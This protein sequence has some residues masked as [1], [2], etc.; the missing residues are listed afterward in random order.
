M[1]RSPYIGLHVAATGRRATAADIVESVVREIGTGALPAGSRLPPVRALEKQLGLSKNT[2]QAAYDE[3]VA[4]GV[5]EAREREGVFVLAASRQAAPEPVI[6]APPAVVVPPPLSRPD[7]APRGSIALSTVFIDPELLPTERIA[8]CARSVLRERM[9]THYDPQGYAPL[10]E[11]IAKRLQ[12]RGLDVEADD[13]VV[14]TGSQQSL[15]IVA[16][17]L[18]VRRI[19]V[20]SPV[21]AYAKILFETLG[22]EL[23]GLTLDPFGGIDLDTWDRALARKP[24]LAYLIP[25]FHNPTGYSYTSAELRGVLELCSKHG[26]AILEDDWGSDMLSDGEYRPMLRM[27]GGRD[28]LYVNSFTKKLLPSLRV[29]FVA[30]S[31]A[32][33]PTLVAMKRL[34]TLGNAWLTEAI[35]AEFLARGY[36]DTHLATLQT[37]LDARYAAC[38]TALDE[39]MPDG[40]KWT[41]PGGGPTLWLEIPRS[42]DLPALEAHL[43]RR[44]VHIASSSA[45]FVG[46]P[47]LHGFR[48]AYAYLHEDDMR[49]ALTIVADALRSLR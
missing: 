31:P 46:A 7:V 41:H 35:V 5:V 26:V 45:A 48:I 43:A 6:V 16:R 49:R 12:A 21:Y 15:D 27:L 32:L 28:V 36:Y 23:V 8:E 37:A 42:I 29:G 30:A 38:L 22:H 4:R 24:A 25:S 39:L 11:V 2:A 17:S 1:T 47:T 40:V 34:S 14:T 33:V 44:G 19:A 9:A 10:R 20:E 18:A 3:L 13:I